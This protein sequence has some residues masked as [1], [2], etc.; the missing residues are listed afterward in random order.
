ML[1]GLV[2]HRNVDQLF[3]VEERHVGWGSSVTLI[4][5]HVFNTIVLPDADAR[6]RRLHND[7]TRRIIFFTGHWRVGLAACERTKGVPWVL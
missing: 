7:T 6:V 1:S 3:C 2:L 4:V 5:G